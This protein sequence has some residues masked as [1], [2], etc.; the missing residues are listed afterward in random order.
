MLSLGLGGGVGSEG[1][2]VGF[3]RRGTCCLT[4]W[5]F[6]SPAALGKAWVLGVPPLPH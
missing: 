2:E 1:G 4:L 3:C 5:F 6:L